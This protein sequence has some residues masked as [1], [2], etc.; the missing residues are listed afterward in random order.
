MQKIAIIGA[1]AAGCFCAI[2]IK[3][4]L[5]D[6]SVDIYEGGRKAMSKL[7]ITG[8]GRCNLTNSFANADSLSSIY[9]RGERL[10]KRALKVFG[11]QDV[12]EWFENE[13]VRL[14]VQEDDCVFPKSQDAMEIVRTLNRSM[15][16]E[17]IGIHTSHKLSA[18][19]KSSDNKWKLFF[20]NGEETESD[21]L[22]VATGSPNKSIC[23]IFAGLG[24]EIIEPIP[25]LFTF[26]MPDDPIRSLM[27][28]VVEKASVSIVGSS[29][30]SAG[31]ILITDWGLSGPAILKLSSYAARYFSEHGYNANISINWAGDLGRED[32][33]AVLRK[34]AAENDRKLVSS[35]RPNSLPSRLWQHLLLSSG[36]REDIRWAEIGKKGLNRLTEQIMNDTHRV[37]GKSRHRDEFVTCGGISLSN[38]SISTME[39]KFHPGL[40]FAGEVL[41]VDAVTGGFN[42][43]AAWSMAYIAAE[44]ISKQMYD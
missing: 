39:C 20:E 10:M 7:S 9:P 6:S 2:Q 34:I 22:V 1:G 41:D 24:L 37:N 36:L 3:R 28:T 25:S 32:I 44:S 40:Y 30:K 23:N 12:M 15:L 42:L 38:I 14:V 33:I 27:G 31:A 18:L 35:A 29:Y 4:R 8:G 19:S 11:S 17:H 43:Q 16:N 13:G 21:L 26:S 5:P